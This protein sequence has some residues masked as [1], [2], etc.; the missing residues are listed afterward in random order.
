MANTREC[1]ATYYIHRTDRRPTTTEGGLHSLKVNP[2]CREVYNIGAM[3]TYTE[4]RGL[5]QEVAVS[6]LWN[7]ATRGQK[8]EKCGPCT[9]RR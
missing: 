4:V 6:K 1:E 3:S 9:M 5:P 7:A 8:V 2:H